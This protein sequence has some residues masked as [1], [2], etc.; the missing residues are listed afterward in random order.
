MW[1]F[2]K[3]HSIDNTEVSITFA[4]VCFQIFHLILI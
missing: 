2:P 3:L 1:A 4:I